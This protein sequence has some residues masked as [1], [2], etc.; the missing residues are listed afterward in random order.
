VAGGTRFAILSL[1]IVGGAAAWLR[2]RDEAKAWLRASAEQGNA[3]RRADQGA[4][5]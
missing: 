4:R 3:M 1:L 2:F 5:T